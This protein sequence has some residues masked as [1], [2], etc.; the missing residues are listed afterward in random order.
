MKHILERHAVKI[1]FAIV[2]GANTAVDFG[3]LLLLAS[4]GFDRIISNYISTSVAFLLSFFLNRSYT[5]QSTGEMKKQI[6][7]FL[8]VTLTGLWIIQP[9]VI[10]S[11]AWIISP[12]SLS[13]DIITIIAK[14]VATITSLVWNYILYSKLVFTRK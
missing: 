13:E 8:V 9:I 5:F 4:I 2:G 7:P 3:I 6:G 14:L 12:T 1:R 11:V 10:G